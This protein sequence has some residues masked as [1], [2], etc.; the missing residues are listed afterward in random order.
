MKFVFRTLA[1]ARY[2]TLRNQLSTA[3]PVNGVPLECQAFMDAGVTRALAEPPVM[4]LVGGGA[5]VRL[6]YR[7]VHG[8]LLLA[9]P[10]YA[11][12]GIDTDPLELHFQIGARY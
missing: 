10:I 2:L 11:S 9:A 3:C 12:T 1:L 8:E 4:R 5:G 7:H 6:A